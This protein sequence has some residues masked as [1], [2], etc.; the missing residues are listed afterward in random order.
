[1]ISHFT[2]YQASK[3]DSL[4]QSE[5]GGPPWTVEGAAQSQTC[6]G[7]WV[8][9]KKTGRKDTKIPV[10]QWK[11]NTLEVLCGEL[12]LHQLV[13]QKSEQLLSVSLF[14]I[15]AVV[16]LLLKDEVFLFFSFLDLITVLAHLGSRFLTWFPPAPLVH[17]FSLSFSAAFPPPVPHWLVPIQMALHLAQFSSSAHPC[18]FRKGWNPS[19]TTHLTWGH[20][21]TTRT[22]S[23]RVPLSTYSASASPTSM[24]C[25]FWCFFFFNLLLDSHIKSFI[26][27]A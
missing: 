2:G 3:L 17:V 26:L 5:Q 6:P 7:E 8:K 23:L 19:L 20:L 22:L 27:K 12:F 10:G 4:F 21:K 11:V 9:T 1:M 14:F 16:C 15:R 25:V 24:F 18:P 13:T